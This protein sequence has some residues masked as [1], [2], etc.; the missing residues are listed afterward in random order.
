MSAKSGSTR[1]QLGHQ[2]GLQ[3]GSNVGESSQQVKDIADYL[4]VDAQ[5]AFADYRATVEFTGSS[6]RAIRESA[7]NGGKDERWKQCEDFIANAPQWKGGETRRGIEL[8]PEKYAHIKVGAVWDVNGGGPAS[9]STEAQT[10]D[11]FAGNS[12]GRSVVFITK[13][14]KSAT[15]IKGI[16]KFSSENEVLSSMKNRYRITG[17]SKGHGT[18]NNR[19]YVEVEAV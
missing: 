12:A 18:Y 11:S 16:S 2:D 4:G 17:V 5:R 6:Y 13:S 14:H 15:S 3:V 1:V 19:L 8:S 7:R 9:W 10:A